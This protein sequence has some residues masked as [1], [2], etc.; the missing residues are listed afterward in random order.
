MPFEV[1]VG[2]RR[3][4]KNDHKILRSVIASLQGTTNSIPEAAGATHVL[5]A[6]SG[7]DIRKRGWRPRGSVGPGISALEPPL[8]KGVRNPLNGIE[9]PGG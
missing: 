3:E 8:L 1:S 6:G 7:D 4:E 5:P 2:Q 9:V